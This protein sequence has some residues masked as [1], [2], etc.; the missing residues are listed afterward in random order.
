MITAAEFHPTCASQLV[1]SSSKGLCDCATY[2]NRARRE[3]VGR[4]F[5]PCT[6]K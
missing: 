1:Y 4:T 2:A 3:D 6:A 5:W